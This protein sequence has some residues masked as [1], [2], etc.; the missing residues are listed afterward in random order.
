VA[1]RALEILKDPRAR[2]RELGPLAL[3]IGRRYHWLLLVL[4]VGA[5]LRFWE[6]SAYPPSVFYDEIYPYTVVLDQL[7]GQGVYFTPTTSFGELLARAVFGQYTAVGALGPTTW[8]IRVPGAL[9]GLL[10]VLGTFLLGRTL[11]EE[12]VGLWAA[13]LV[14]LEPL[15]VEGSRVLYMAEIQDAVAITVI[16]TWL[17]IT[18]LRAAGPARVRLYGSYILFGLTTGYFFSSYSRLTSAL[19]LGLLVLYALWVHRRAWPRRDLQN[20]L[21][22]PL[23]AE[24]FFLVLVPLLSASTAATQ[25]NGNATLYFGPA[26]LLLTGHPSDLATFLTRYLQYYSPGFLL[27]H[28]DPNPS[29]NTGLTGEMLYPGAVF[30]YVGL[31]L[32]ASTLLRRRGAPFPQLLVLLWLA[33]APVVAAAF[34]YNNYTDSSGA[35]FL[36]PALEIIAALGIVRTLEALDRAQARWRPAILRR[37][38]RWEV[39]FRYRAS[40]AGTVVLVAALVVSSAVFVDAYFVRAPPPVLND[41]NSQWGAMFGFPQAALYLASHGGASRPVYVSPDGLFGNNHTLFDLYF[42]SL[43]TP[44]NYL[45]YYSNGQI[46]NV[47]E[48][49][50]SNYYSAVPAYVLTGSAGDVLALRAHGLTATQSFVQ[51]RPDGAFAVGVIDTEPGLNASRLSYLQAHLAFS[52][53]H[54]LGPTNL[55]APGLRSIRDTFSMT[56][57]FTIPS[58]P[59]TP[60]GT[61][62]LVDNTNPTFSIGYWSANSF[63]SAASAWQQFPEGAVYSRASTDLPGSWDRLWSPQPLAPGAKYAVTI[64]SVNGSLSIYVNQSLEGSGALSYPLYPPGSE[65]LLDSNNTA[66]LWSVTVWSV[67]LNPV[68]VAYL[69]YAEGTR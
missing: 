56:A 24:A 41:P 29:Q 19:V 25:L 4:L 52:A 43:S 37:A 60:G 6:L 48:V 53:S 17:F 46:L 61:Y 51:Y 3:A 15:A 1:A 65:M 59:F 39:V 33:S 32:L 21:L 67:A 45:D 63:E 58:S 9:Y 13:F 68:D 11:F 54:L 26:N 47:A 16:A 40:R 12:R 8:A 36:L 7:R 20:L 28:G 18:G 50:I 27:V 23:A 69:Y 2:W 62:H 38:P 49:N 5:G 34:L 31:L 66:F 22:Y 10:L 42:H 30:L 55:S 14:A 44:Q 57:V 64:E 35:Q